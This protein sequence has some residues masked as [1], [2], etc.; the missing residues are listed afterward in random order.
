[1]A[2]PIKEIYDMYIVPAKTPGK[3]VAWGRTP[4]G[5]GGMKDIRTSHIVE[6]NVDEGYVETLNTRYIIK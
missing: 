1:M 3:Q 4:D 2:K 6:H 5:N